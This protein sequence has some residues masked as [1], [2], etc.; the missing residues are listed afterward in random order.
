MQLR[1]STFAVLFS[2]FAAMFFV[3]PLAMTAQKI[4]PPALLDRQTST[5]NPLARTIADELRLAGD[6]LIGRGVA[7]DP[8]QSAYWYR[9]AADQGD[10]NAQNQLGYLY[11]WGIGVER[12]PAEAAKWFMRAAGSGSQP[13]S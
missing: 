9:K 13:P 10:P 3:A 2:A 1:R 12:D 8:A 5:A 4:A 11:S 6:F 7:K